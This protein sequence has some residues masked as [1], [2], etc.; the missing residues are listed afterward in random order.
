MADRFLVIVADERKIFD[1]FPLTVRSLRD[2]DPHTIRV[3]MNR[4][5]GDERLDDHRIP[6]RLF[7]DAGDQFPCRTDG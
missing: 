1:E 6:F 4:L 2:M 3:P 7:F 5:R